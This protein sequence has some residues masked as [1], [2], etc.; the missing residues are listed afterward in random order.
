[1]RKRLLPALLALALAA[2]LC[3]VAP[4]SGQA[5]A[6]K[7]A[8]LDLDLPS[9]TVGTFLKALT[10]GSDLKLLTSAELAAEKVA[11]Y[12]PSVT[13]RE[14]LD[15]VC[16]AHGLEV[17][18]LEGTN[19]LIVKRA[20]EYVETMDTAIFRL[21]HIDAEDVEP[22]VLAVL[23]ITGGGTATRAGLAVTAGIDKKNNVIA[24]RAPR[25]DL[26]A[27]RDMIAQ[28]DVMRG[29]VLIEAVLVEL[30]EDAERKLGIKWEPIAGYTGPSRL[31]K[32]PLRGGWVSTAEDA[33]AWEYGR[34][35]FQEFF[36]R[37]EALQSEGEA[38]ILASPRI[39]TI[40]GKEAEIRIVNNIVVA[41]EINFQTGEV[42]VITEEPVTAEVGVILKTTPRIHRDGSVTLVVEPEVSTA[43][44]SA[45]FGEEFVD[46]FKR[47]ASTTVLL[48]D[49][50]TI[51]IGGLLRDDET[52]QI[53]K[54]PF[55]GNVPFIKPLFTHKRTVV[56]KTDLVVFLTP[57]LLNSERILEDTEAHETRLREL[58]EE[59]EARRSPP[60]DDRDSLPAPM[61]EP[62][63]LEE[64]EAD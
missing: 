48:G 46:T 30:S 23:G 51:A 64:V 59:R 4:A 12:L 41:T 44:T 3:R 31:T 22:V 26:E 16:A 17:Q 8:K 13:A 52:E 28:A 5:N 7:P 54:V 20:A 55:L 15:A 38:K 21:E 35:S 56:A 36:I 18:E 10:E 43:S 14:A 33:D 24:V 53:T 32:V 47:K 39:T 9:V 29:Q 27:V 58:Q 34:V 63:E 45:F 42:D 40:D 62:I 25:K 19:I 37:L 50:E 2:G 60:P 11:V 49:G 6:E 1:M 61:V 57:R